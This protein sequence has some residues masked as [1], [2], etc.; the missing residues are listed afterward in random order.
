MIKFFRHIRL[1]L[2]M[3]KK[4]S[5]YFRYAIGEI[6]LVVIGIL[7]ALQINNWN[8]ENNKQKKL[9]TYLIALKTEL[10]NNIIQLGRASE[11]SRE[12][13]TFCIETMR[14][15]NSDSAKF[16]T[17][18]DVRKRNS[19][20]VFKIE[21]YS[22]VFQ[23]M[24]SSGVLEN[25]NDIELKQQI[26]RIDRHLANYDEDFDNAKN[27]WENYMLPYHSKHVNVPSL[28]DSINGV[29]LPK[30][31]FKNDVEAFAYNRDYTNILG[32]RARMLANI[33]N[34]SK[35]IKKDFEILINNID[36]Y[37]NHD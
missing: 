6:L 25:L 9:E 15:F 28:W 18:T 12:D 27:I 24:I 5:R 10:N 34:E 31:N 19:G 33:E 29:A 1:T 30:L 3:E 22:S 7:I 17:S 2:I 16:L 11:R 14:V 26:F 20:P 37:L 8:E 4:T 23:D 13:F 35:Y 32:S 36:K 21:L